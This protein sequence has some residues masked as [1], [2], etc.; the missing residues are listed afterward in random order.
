MAVDSTIALV[1]AAEA[2]SHLKIDVATTE[3]D[4]D[5][6]NLVNSVSALCNSYTKR[7]LLSGARTEL[8]ESDDP[9]TLFL[10]D[11]PVSTLT[12]LYIDTERVYGAD[13]EVVEGEYI[14]YAD[15]G[16]IVLA[17]DSFSNAPQ[18][19][20]IEY[21]AGYAL[22]NVP[23]DLKRACLDQIKFLFNRWKNNREAVTSV[24]LEGQSIALVEVKDLLP[25]VKQVLDM[26]VRKGHV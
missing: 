25:S 8:K 21:T 14:L 7:N 19:I 17:N 20:K 9:Y 2:K 18:A 5:I 1:T 4:T 24:G 11:Y 15:S 12:H 13:T 23:Y 10:K 16:K 6:E 26:Y 3:Y 22:A